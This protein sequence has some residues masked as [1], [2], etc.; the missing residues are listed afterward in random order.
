MTGYDIVTPLFDAFF[1]ALVGLGLVCL[2]VGLAIG[3]AVGH[4]LL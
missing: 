3:W 4:F 1:M 2:S